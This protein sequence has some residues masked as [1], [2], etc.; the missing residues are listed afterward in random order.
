MTLLRLIGEVL[1]RP[2]LITTKILFVLVMEVA[3]Q[4]IAAFVS[5]DGKR[6]LQMKGK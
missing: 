6:K 5:Q 1:P 2:K 4:T 3:M